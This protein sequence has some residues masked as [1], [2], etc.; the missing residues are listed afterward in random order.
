MS[1][2]II[3]VDGPSAV[4]KG[5]LSRKLAKEF[6]LD[7][8]DT[9]RL[10]R[11][12]AYL[13]LKNTADSAVKISIKDAI[14]SAET[15]TYDMLSM[16][17]LYDLKIANYASKLAKISKVREKLLHWQQN[18][19]QTTSDGKQGVILDGRDIGTVIAPK[20]DVKIFLK[21]SSSIRATRRYKETL[22]R[23]ENYTY[24]VIL[25]QLKDRDQ[26][27]LLRKNAPCVPAKDAVIVDTDLLDADQTFKFCKKVV[28][29]KMKKDNI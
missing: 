26:N 29:H 3:A 16:Q 11:A 21:A 12:T 1:V 17:K 7:Y 27:D 9:G 25:R 10:Y 24:E 4:G 14:K 20:A 19:C 6:N 23:G 28:N 5:T 8:L 15:I 18:F 13:Y 2:F 22:D